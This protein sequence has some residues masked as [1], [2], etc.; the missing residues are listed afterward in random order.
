M[1]ENRFVEVAKHAIG[2]GHRNPYTRHGKRFYR[3]YRNYFA[4]AIGSA[5]FELWEMLVSAG[6]VGIR[7]DR[8]HAYFWLTRSGLDWLGEKLG[9]YIHDEE[10]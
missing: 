2:M 3:P 1:N 7:K 8:E 9:I 6:Y 10:D 5:D 4:A